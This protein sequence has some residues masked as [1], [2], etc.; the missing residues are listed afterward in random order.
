[1][2]GAIRKLAAV[3][4]GGMM[5]LILG[6]TFVQAVVGPRYRDDPRNARVILSLSGKERGLIVTAD[7][8][9]VAQSV[10]DPEDPRRYFRQ[11]PYGELYAHAVGYS[12]LLFG[13]EGIEAAFQNDLRSKRDLTISDLLT[14][15]LGR[16]LR[17]RS[18]QVTLDHELQRAADVALGE[19]SGAVVAIDPRTGAV[20]ALVSHPSFDPNTL[21]GT[22][23]AP[24]RARLTADPRQPLLDRAARQS[25]P[26][27]STF[28]VVTAA[29]ALEE[30]LAG[31]GTTFPNPEALQLPGSSSTIRNFDLG[32]CGP[33]EE[34]S[35]E[36]AFRRSCNTIFAMLAMQVGA[37]ALWRR[38]EAFGFN[39][40]LPLET[41]VLPSVFP[42]PSTFG[43][44]LPAV[45]QSGIGHRDVQATVFQ[46]ALVA[47]AV[48]NDGLTMS[49]HL[50]S[51]VVDADGR[52]VGVVE[53]T[54]LSRAVSPGTSLVLVDM[55][56]QVVT[57]GT[58]QMAQVPG[59]RVAGKTG[60][61]GTGGGPPDVWFVGFAPVDGPTIAIAVLVEAGGDAGENATGGRVAAP[62]AGEILASWFERNS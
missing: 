3:L 56:E 23:A 24:V 55:M 61:A 29:A 34:V 21:L 42:R 5:L 57:S 8:V 19:R 14:A 10:R 53:P 49:P 15:L 18:I 13:D 4:L 43:D 28:K 26:P 32:P 27:G 40:D 20:L 60:T 25:Y 39:S 58:G 59:V 31:A 17:A 36:E 33:A 16:D 54:V 9:T 12:S 2:N 52:P 51:T 35:L 62:I 37:E 30:G 41:S 44:D 38:A 45:A 6:A 50:V 47:A 48:A 1:M 46:M 7:G 22:G 11:Y